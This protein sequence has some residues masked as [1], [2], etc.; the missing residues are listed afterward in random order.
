[1]RKFE[2]VLLIHAHQPVGNFDNVFEH[3][4]V[5]S[6]LP[7][8]QVLARHPQ[9]RVGLHYSGPLL[10]WIE[11][12]HPEYFEQLRELAARGQAEIIG[13]GFYEPILATI[14]PKDRHAQITTLAQY[15]EKHF[16]TR[17]KG[18]WLAER[19]WEPQIPSTL[20][21]A[22]AEYTLV[23][24]N[25][26]VAAGFEEERLY[27]YYISEDLGQSVRVLPGLKIL[28]YYI[29]F[30]DVTETIEYLHRCA[31]QHPEGFA[32]MG[33][34]MEKFGIWPG[35]YDLCYRD[36]WLDRFFVALEQSAD[37][38]TL[39]TP[40]DA[41]S[42]HAPLG[43]ADLPMA[44]YA[45]MAEWSLPTPARIRY[46][47][48]V[49]EFSSR[50]DVLP[51]LRGGVWRQFLSKYREANLLHKKMLCVSQ[52]VSRLSHSRSKRQKSRDERESAE[53]SLLRGQCNDSYWHGIFGG[54]Y[55]PHLRTAAWLSLARAETIADRLSHRARQFTKAQTFDFDGDGRDEI[56][57][58]SDQYAALISPDDGGTISAIDFRPPNVTLI[59]SL[60]R[61]PEAYHAKLRNPPEGQT[62]G[63]HSIHEQ[64]R[65]KE[66]GLDRWLHYD[67][68]P[69]NAFRLLL[70]GREKC[71][72][73]CTTVR[74]E[75]DA[76]LAGGEY[77]IT[78]VSPKRVV[79]ASPD[80]GNWSAEKSFSFESVPGGF[81]ITCDA[82][83]RRHAPGSASVTVAIEVVVNFLA[84]STPDR[85]FESDG[86]RFPL[87]WAAEVPGPE[88]RVVDEWQRASVDFKARDAREFWVSPIDTVSESEDGFERIYQGSQLLAVWPVELTK[89]QE[90]RGRLVFT[91]AQLD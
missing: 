23:D 29:P 18:A 8:I 90:W 6:Y 35:T 63:V 61:R 1:L 59:N 30:R 5:K 65:M 79:L 37:W 88:L 67:R 84:P 31:N 13:G 42:S 20:A 60:Q 21:A 22:G 26:F 77:R 56:Y 38:L 7:F 33:D 49:R 17:P 40:S 9:I 82:A 2:L 24:D 66:E 68:W 53:T 14:P 16:G 10:E 41:I 58:T 27:G 32:T 39:N 34:D 64:M 70:F 55:S 73:D 76:T 44:S 12:K 87:R 51:F 91:V 72:E 81:A 80:S 62:Q 69:R 57:L 47:D 43:R 28:R 89:D 25:H 11:H 52:K 48:L 75:E 45:E 78:E 86:R 85:Y 36:G 74:L 19:V 4:Y 50:E 3:A 46:H 71:F 54:L 83:I 15:I